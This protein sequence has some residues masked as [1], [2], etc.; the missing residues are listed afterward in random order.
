MSTD[1]STYDHRRKAKLAILT[2][3]EE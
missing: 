3:T 2:N 1:V